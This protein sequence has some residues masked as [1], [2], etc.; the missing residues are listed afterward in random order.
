MEF[1]VGSEFAEVAVALDETANGLRLRLTDL[2]SGHTRH[3]D[4]LELEA[5]TWLSPER[6]DRMLD[7]SFD[8]WRDAD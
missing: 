6:F 3:L 4:A 8:R 1:I 5:L 7:P 2:R